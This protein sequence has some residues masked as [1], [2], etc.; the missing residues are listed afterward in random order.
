VTSTDVLALKNSDLNAFLFADVGT[1][2]NGSPLTI[3]SV[4]ARLGQDPWAEAARWAK[5]PRGAAIDCLAQ[6][7]AKMPLEPQALAATF[8]TAAW[9]VQLLPIQTGD[10]PQ[11]ISGGGRA[12]T[13]QEWISMALLCLSLIVGVLINVITDRPS[14]GTVNATTPRVH[15]GSNMNRTRAARPLVCQQSRPAPAPVGQLAAPNNIH[16]PSLVNRSNF[17]S[18]CL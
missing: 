6:S 3:L 16:R 18:T 5:M 9:L 15:F 13:I 14:T 17:V 10:L 12:L 11:R 7:I 4:L 8:A 2:L 1:E